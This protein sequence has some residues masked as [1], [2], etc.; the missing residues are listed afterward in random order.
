MIIAIAH[1]DILDLSIMSYYGIHFQ[2][3]SY[4]GLHNFFKKTTRVKI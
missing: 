4:I 1:I 3:E 2:A